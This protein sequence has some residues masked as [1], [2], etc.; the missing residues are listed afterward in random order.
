M[1]PTNTPIEEQPFRGPIEWPPSGPIPTR[2]VPDTGEVAPPPPPP[3]A[4][5][6]PPPPPP[7]H[8]D[9]MIPNQ[10]KGSAMSI[11]T[12]RA[13]GYWQAS[14]GQ[15]YPPQQQN[16]PPTVIVQKKGGCFRWLGIGVVAFVALIVVGGIIAAVSGNSNSNSN[17]GSSAVTTPT[18][19]TIS[20]GAHAAADDVTVAG[21][22]VDAVGDP[23]AHVTTLNHSSKTSNYIV[24]VVFETSDG[25]TQIDT[26][27][28]A[29]NNL[30]PGQTSND[31]AATFK[32]TPAGSFTCKVGNVTRY[33]AP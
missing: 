13:D 6:P 22:S 8:G 14:D 26:G 9:H 16:A 2:Y 25:A 4:T 18:G 3:Q 10:E 27:M 20:A 33:A 23:V 5:P 30:A 17:G 31:D 19:G 21:C 32:S 29:V 24:Q 1:S 11:P 15:W 12:A 28:V 7:P